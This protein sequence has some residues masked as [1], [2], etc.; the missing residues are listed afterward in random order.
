MK[1]HFPWRTIMGVVM[2]AAGTAAAHHSGAAFDNSKR[3][4][5][6]GTVKE[7]EWT[8]P[9]AWLQLEVPDAKGNSVEEGFE[10]GSPNTMFRDGFRINSFK[11]GDVVSVVAGPRRDGGPG[12]A[13]IQVKTASG[14]WLQWGQGADAVAAKA[15]GA[16]TN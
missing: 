9:H 11:P 8:N 13:L 15:S 7:W 4:T 6:T 14:T 10:A 12:G 2:L 5:V 16:P 3:V 1:K